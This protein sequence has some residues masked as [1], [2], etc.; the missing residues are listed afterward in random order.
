MIWTG[1]K[2]LN[3]LKKLVFEDTDLAQFLKAF[4]L[5]RQLLIQLVAINTAFIQIKKVHS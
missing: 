4:H 5:R 3:L 1:G 2:K